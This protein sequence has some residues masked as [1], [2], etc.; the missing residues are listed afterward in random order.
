MRMS[1]RSFA[2]ASAISVDNYGIK[3]YHI[4][5]GEIRKTHIAVFRILR[6]FLG[7]LMRV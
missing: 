5:H 1:I 7:V 6:A 3:C 4:I 2:G